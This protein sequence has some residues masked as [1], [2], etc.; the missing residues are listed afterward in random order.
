MEAEIVDA[1]PVAQAGQIYAMAEKSQLEA[2]IDAAHKYPRNITRFKQEVESMALLDPETAQQMGYA[3]PQ[4]GGTVKGPS[5]RLAE[6]VATAWGNLRYG[7]R[8]IETTESTV[9]AEGFCFDCEKNTGA[10]ATATKSIIKRDGSRYSADMI[11]NTGNAL[12]SIALRNA[13]FRVVPRVYV[14]D[15]Y[16]KAM[17]VAYG[18]SVSLAEV[19]EKC[20]KHVRGLGITDDRILAVVKRPGIADVTMEDVATL[21]ALCVTIKEGELTVEQAFPFLTTEAEGEAPKEAPKG[22]TKSRVKDKLKADT[23]PAETQQQASTAAEPPKQDAAPPADAIPAKNSG[24]WG[25][26]KGGWSEPR[27][28]AYDSEYAKL[29]GIGYESEDAHQEAYQAALKV[30]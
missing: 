3:K 19:R 1:M 30:A 6:I 2:A 28:G 29:M 23:P 4:A 12:C 16:E 26:I 8:V 5:T 24:S 20:F 25:V 11:V 14:D 21:R 18:K 22:G 7:A 17:A 15:V 9:T 27:Q 13:I 10:K